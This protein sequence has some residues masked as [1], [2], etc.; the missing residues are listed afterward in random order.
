MSSL[1]ISLTPWALALASACGGD[2]STTPLTPLPPITPQGRG[3][4]KPLRITAEVAVR[5]TTAYTTTWGNSAAAA[6][7]FHIWNV[8]G[9]APRL[10]DSVRVDDAITLG[11]VAISDDGTLLVIATEG[12][13]AGLAIYSIT[14]PLRPVAIARYSSA[15][16]SAGV[17]TAELGRVNGTL[18]GFLAVDPTASRASHLV[19]VDLSVPAAPVEVL[20][21]D[22]GRP[23]IHDT[24]VRDGLLFLALWDDGLAIWD[25]GGGGAGGTVRAPVELGR[26]RTVNG[27]VHN[28]WWLK[29]PVTGIAR[30]ALVGEEG[31][32]RVG[33]SSSGDVHVVDISTPSAP[34]EVAYYTV[35]GAGT[36]NFS[37][38]EQRGILYAA[39]YNGGV[40]A[41][42]VRGDLGT[43]PDSQRA[44]PANGTAALC[45]LTR[46]GRQ[47]KVELLDRSVPVYI[48]GVQYLD[49]A[50]YASDML[51]GLWKLPA[52]SRP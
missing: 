31:A 41:L 12:S 38:D 32:G 21:R 34:R 24:F 8:A 43:C 30:Y 27:A 49:G 47:L 2:A 35:P 23:F 10:V 9:G 28:V 40:R 37:V 7:V 48:W 4:F 6:S 3:D 51:N 17:H 29:D 42:D 14:D 26:L 45:E 11:D 39:Y 25:I 5:G 36:H 20:S 19:V 22:L 46:M 33:L 52:S 44:I 1:W 18:Y 13:N 15:N 16:T 50:V